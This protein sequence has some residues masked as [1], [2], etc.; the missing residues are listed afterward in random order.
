MRT[1]GVRLWIGICSSMFAVA[2]VTSYLAWNSLTSLTESSDLAQASLSTD[3]AAQTDSETTAPST[4]PQDAA[5]SPGAAPRTQAETDYLLD[6]SQGLQTPERDRLNSTQQLQIAQDILGWLREGA[7]YW[8]VREK[9]DAAYRSQIAGDYA[10]NRDVYIRFATERFAPDH[11]ATLKQ[12]IEEQPIQVGALP[13]VPIE[14]AEVAPLDSGDYAPVYP[15]PPGDPY[16][17]SGHPFYPQ[18]SYRTRRIYPRRA[19]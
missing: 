10:H 14:T 4:Q 17:R 13:E 8:G 5:A 19:F 3:P 9:F 2:G 15:Y 7:D 18:P 1:S 6:L 12:P 16:V 11:R